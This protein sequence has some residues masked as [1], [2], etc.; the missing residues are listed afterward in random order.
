MPPEEEAQPLQLSSV[1]FEPSTKL[2]LSAFSPLGTALPESLFPTESAQRESP[3]TAKIPS[4]SLAVAISKGVLVSTAE[5]SILSHGE[6][7][8]S[9]SV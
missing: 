8:V 6:E 3:S 1:E 5:V 9:L 7:D 4:P 2:T